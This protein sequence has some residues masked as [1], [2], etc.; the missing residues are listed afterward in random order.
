MFL[1][2]LNLGLFYASLAFG[3]EQSHQ[4][5]RAISKIESRLLISRQ[6]LGFQPKVE[7]IKIPGGMIIK[8]FDLNNTEIGSTTFVNDRL[9]PEKSYLA[10]VSSEVSGA[11][12][13]ALMMVHYTHLYPKV[14]TIHAR[15]MWSNFRWI[16]RKLREGHD[17][18]SA[19]KET[20]TV[21]ALFKIG[22][23]QLVLTDLNFDK[24]YADIKAS[25]EVN[26]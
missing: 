22:F 12:L 7:Q 3:V 6:K 15:L 9:D 18:I 20:S 17:P 26:L 14:K 5:S 10:S 16:E 2:Y 1:F 25:L 19:V 11:E 23:D 24:Q 4:C 13:Q 8:V 21:K